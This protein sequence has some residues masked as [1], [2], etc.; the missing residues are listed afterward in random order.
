MG[1]STTTDSPTSVFKTLDQIGAYSFEAW[2]NFAPVLGSILFWDQLLWIN[3]SKNVS[4]KN[5]LIDITPTTSNTWRAIEWFTIVNKTYKPTTSTTATWTVKTVSST[6]SYSPWDYIIFQNPT[7]GAETAWYIATVDSWTQVTLTAAV[8]T[9]SWDIV[10]RISF[11]KKKWAAIDRVDYDQSRNKTSNYIQDFGTTFSTDDDELNSHMDFTFRWG[12]PNPKDAK[13]TNKE[14]MI[15]WVANFLR[16]KTTQKLGWEIIWDIAWQFVR[17][18]KNY[19]ADWG[20]NR[21]F[22]G[23][24]YEVES[25]ESKSWSVSSDE[26]IDWIYSHCYD[27]LNY[28]QY[29][30]NKKVVI[31]CNNAFKKRFWMLEKSNVRINFAP[32]APEVWYKLEKIIFPW[33]DDIY[34]AFDPKVNDIEPDSLP[35]AHIMPLDLVW[36]YRRLYRGI[37]ENMDAENWPADVLIKKAIWDEDYLDTTTLYFAYNLAFIFWGWDSVTNFWTW[38]GLYRKLTITA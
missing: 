4:F 27:V 11:S 15:Y 33:F 14:K 23:W 2:E 18:A 1:F 21:Y 24:L 16:M 5:S 30:G 17:W 32:A 28:G 9:T 10:K 38:K 19:Y 34:I 3:T 26:L 36:A 29:Y 8:A 7:T 12:V 6:T 13:K 35:V 25:T 37:N 22:T 20:K 31:M